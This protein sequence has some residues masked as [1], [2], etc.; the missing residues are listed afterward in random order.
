MLNAN[1]DGPNQHSEESKGGTT[2]TLIQMVV[3]FMDNPIY[4]QYTQPDLSSD[5][6]R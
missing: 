1:N 6:K 2:N 4:N 3:I 5:D